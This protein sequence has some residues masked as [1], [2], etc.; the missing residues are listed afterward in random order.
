M[1]MSCWRN[2]QTCLGKVAKKVEVGLLS[3]DGRPPALVVIAK[4]IGLSTLSALMAAFK[5]ILIHGPEDTR[6]ILNYFL[7]FPPLQR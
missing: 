4:P 5:L 2:D 7:F 6:R 3:L 1:S